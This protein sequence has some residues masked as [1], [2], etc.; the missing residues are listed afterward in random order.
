MYS[1]RKEMPE[2]QHNMGLSVFFLLDY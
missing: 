2:M 1:Q